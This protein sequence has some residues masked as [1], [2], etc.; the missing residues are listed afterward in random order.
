MINSYIRTEGLIVLSQQCFPQFERDIL[1]RA[2]RTDSHWA[3]HLLCAFQT[4]T[5]LSLV[6]DYAEGGTLWDVLES[7]PHDGKV[8]ET[9]LR[10]WVPQ[11]V[12]AI[13]WC[14]SQG[15]VHRDIKPHN[16]VLA[17]SA[18]LLLIDF[19]SAAPLLPPD[20]DGSQRVPKQYCLVPCGTCDYISPE[21]LQAH[22]EALVALEM[23]D[24]TRPL[25]RDET[26]GYGR[27]TD[28]WSMGAMLYELAYGVAP[29]FARDIKQ[30]YLKIT[31]HHRSLRF[32]ES[33]SI[34]S[35]LQDLLRRLLTSSELRLGRGNT[36][37]IMWH[38]FFEGIKWS[39]LYELSSPS[40]LH[41]PQFTYS[42]PVQPSDAARPIS[43]SP[44]E[45]SDAPPFAFS[46]LFQS[47]PQSAL[48]ASANPTTPSQHTCRSSLREQSTAS[49]IGFSWGPPA[50]AF[51]TADEKMHT[52]APADIHTPHPLTRLSVPSTPFIQGSRNTINV[53]LSSQRYPFATPIR[54]SA[55]TPHQTLPRAS[56]IRRTAPRR[57][58]SD[59]EAMKQLVDC[60]GMSARKKVLESGRKPRILTSF[61][62]SSALKEL[63]FDTSVIVV[64]DG[65]VSYRTE[66]AAPSLSS[67]SN[68]VL[69][70]LDPVS[71]EVLAEDASFSDAGLDVPPSPSPS[72]RPGSA[73][74]MLS[75]RS[76]TPT[77][78][79]SSYFLKVGQ[80]SI[81]RSD[82]ARPLSPSLVIQDVLQPTESKGRE[83]VVH[84]HLLSYDVLD[85]FDKRYTS[86]MGDIVKLET[87]LGRVASVVGGR[88]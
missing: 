65:G 22:E 16:F 50:D 10:W 55:L 20:Q 66:A 81:H 36:D 29:F 28:W 77:I 58:V 42:T 80:G 17:S 51:P 60:V 21:I 68:S 84:N 33:A 6:M 30:T 87:H 44:G 56:T 62:R 34:S 75:R 15:F 25:S 78:S 35:D 5:H 14:H 47:S 1:L 73:M 7:S 67:L 2:R 40:G 45:P 88:N 23:A 53:T 32:D 64:G 85:E 24:D 63:R 37:E 48:S 83:I 72:P 12:S 74:S 18:H 31:D 3:P 41:L 69:S 79:G 61:S 26:G 19:G 52:F 39:S 9:D 46:A 57:A 13:H 43:S 86:L 38:P 4:P 71:Q 54:P 27:E 11:T 49:F 70:V 8:P 76:Q 59:R 82:E